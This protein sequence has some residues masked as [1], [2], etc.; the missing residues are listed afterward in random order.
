MFLVLTAM[1]TKVSTGLK[2]I[3]SGFAGTSITFV[4]AGVAILSNGD[5]LTVG[6]TIDTEICP[7]NVISIIS[8]NANIITGSSVGQFIQPYM[9]ANVVSPSGG[10]NYIINPD[11]HRVAI[12][13]SF[14]INDGSTILG[15]RS[16]FDGRL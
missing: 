8:S 7:G 4:A 2:Q 6:T 1:Y 9:N 13:V 10:E 12:P 5:D 16:S 11:T 14:T 3:T 15:M